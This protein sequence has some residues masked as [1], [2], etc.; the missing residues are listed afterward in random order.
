VIPG[1]RKRFFGS[2]EC[3]YY[4]RVK[5]MFI[6]ASVSSFEFTAWYMIKHRGNSPFAFISILVIFLSVTHK[7][8]LFVWFL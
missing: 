3:L 4:A 7:P 1:R 5:I 8:P 2:S 6:Y